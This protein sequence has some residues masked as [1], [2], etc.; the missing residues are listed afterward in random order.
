MMARHYDP[1][2]AGMP[3]EEAWKVHMDLGNSHLRRYF[4]E[5]I[6]HDAINAV[7]ETHQA[8]QLEPLSVREAKLVRDNIDKEFAR[9]RGSLRLGYN[10][11]SGRDECGNIDP[12]QLM[13]V[14]DKVL[15]DTVEGYTSQ[16]DDLSPRHIKRH[17]VDGVSMPDMDAIN[18]HPLYRRYRD[19]FSVMTGL[20]AAYTD[21]EQAIAA[22]EP[23]L[24][25]SPYDPRYRN[26]TN[27]LR[28]GS[29][30][31]S[32][33]L[34]QIDIKNI[35]EGIGRINN[36]GMSRA[37]KL[38]TA[39]PLAEYQQQLSE[40]GPT[41]IPDDYTG[42]SQL[43]N[44][45]SDAE[46]RDVGSWLTSGMT[47]IEGNIDITKCM[48]ASA[49]ERARMI[50][51][52]LDKEAVDYTIKRDSK[53]GQI[54]AELAGTKMRIRL[55]EP[56][57]E[58]QHR[59]IGRV[60][61]D[62]VATRFSSGGQKEPQ[63][64]NEDVLTLIDYARGKQVYKDDGVTRIGANS[65]GS[66]DKNYQIQGSGGSA[67]DLNVEV[68]PGLFIRQQNYTRSELTYFP[69]TP[70]GERAARIAVAEMVSNAQNSIETILN[71]DELIDNY[72]A[73]GYTPSFVGPDV[74]MSVRSDYY[75]ALQGEDITLLYPGY[76]QQEYY[77]LKADIERHPNDYD[78]NEKKELLASMTPDPDLSREE[79]VRDHARAMASSWVGS[80]D[81]DRGGEFDPNIVAQYMDTGRGVWSNIDDLTHA[82]RAGNVGVESVRGDGHTHEAIM[83]KTVRFDP[84]TAVDM[85][86]FASSGL[87][88]EMSESSAA[89]IEQLGDSIVDA[90]EHAGM[91]IVDLKIDDKGVVQWM[92]QRYV[93]DGTRNG[94]GRLTET[95][96]GEIG[97]IFT[98]DDNG[99]VTTRFGN[100][101]NDVNYSFVP[102]YLASVVPPE[103]GQSSTLEQR[104][105]LRGFEQVIDEAVRRQVVRDVLTPR[106][107]VGTPTSI[108]GVY[109][110]LQDNRHP[111][112]YYRP[113]LDQSMTE[114]QLRAIVQTE[115]LTVRY[116]K[117]FINESSTTSIQSKMK[118]RL[119]D[120][121]ND[122][123]SDA[124]RLSGYRDM[125]QL[126]M[127][128]SLG[129]FDPVMTGMATNQGRRRY[130][131]PTAE[132]G[133]D[134]RITPGD[135]DAKIP[136]RDLDIASEMMHDSHDRQNMSLGNAI[137]AVGFTGQR[138]TA[139]YGVPE[140]DDDALIISQKFADDIQVRGVD[141]E[142][143]SL[144]PGDKLSDMHG[145]KGV[146]SMVVNTMDDP[147]AGKE[148]IYHLMA[149]NPELDVIMSPFSLMSRHNGGTSRE[150]MSDPHDLT[151]ENNVGELV[152]KPGGMGPLNFV[153]T[154][155]T[156]D[157]KTTAYDAEAVRA[158]KGRR[159]SDQ[160][161]AA[162]MANKCSTTLNHFFAHNDQGVSNFQERLR[163]LGYDM[164]P[165]GEVT[166]HVS[167]D[168]E[169]RH[170]F[171]EIPLMYKGES[172]SLDMKAMKAAFA[173]QI[174]QQGGVMKVP[175]DIRLR[176]GDV[177][178]EVPVLSAHLR[179][180]QTMDDGQISRHNYTR[181]Y[182]SLFEQSVYVRHGEAMHE[183][184]KE[185][186]N[187]VLKNFEAAHGK[188]QSAYDDIAQY[189]VSKYF[190]SKHNTAKRDLMSVRVPH[191]ATAV[192]YPDTTLKPNEIAIS[193]SLAKVL[194]VDPTK[195]ETCKVLMTRDPVWRSE[196]MK[197][198]DVVIKPDSDGPAIAVHPK[199]VQPMDGDFDGDTVGLIGGLPPEVCKELDNKLSVRGS[200]LDFGTGVRRDDGK[201]YDY[202]LVFSSELSTQVAIYNDE[203]N[204]VDVANVNAHTGS[205]GQRLDYLTRR[206][207]E[208]YREAYE[209]C[210][211]DFRD[212]AVY[213]N[214]NTQLL[215]D[216]DG[217]YREINNERD[218]LS[219][220]MNNVQ[221]HAES[222][223][224]CHVTG[225]KSAGKNDERFNDYLYYAGI[226]TSTNTEGKTVYQWDKP[227]TLADLDERYTDAQKATGVKVDGLP[228]GGARWQKLVQTLRGVGL[229]NEAGQLGYPSAQAMAQA[230]HGA[231]DAVYRLDVLRNYAG[232]LWKGYKMTPSMEN[233]RLAW[234]T[235][236]EGGKPVQATREEW[237]NQFEQLYCSKEGMGL[238]VGEDHIDTIADTFSIDGGD[239]KR[240]MLN[241]D[242][243]GWEDLPDTFEVTLLDKLA[244]SPREATLKD[245]VSVGAQVFN[246]PLEQIQTEKIAFNKQVH[247]FNTVDGFDP[248]RGNEATIDLSHGTVSY[249][250]IGSEDIRTDYERKEKKSDR[251]VRPSQ[252]FVQA[253]AD[254]AI[255]RDHASH[256]VPVSEVVT[257]AK[258]VIPMIPRIPTM[259][260]AVDQSV[261]H[262]P[263][264]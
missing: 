118:D 232:N 15:G 218:R 28:G 17:M 245:L 172:T 223:Y 105:R 264:L 35:P 51:D 19:E 133:M 44:Y 73:E 32:I 163:V 248:T 82:M 38:T 249:Q 49:I 134:G 175:F 220:N 52:H 100:V 165:Y 262:G 47:D 68:R 221:D 98:R 3:E 126:S 180:D 130:L 222:L 192:W 153:V 46:Y 27:V 22:F 39:H 96:T 199:I 263:E 12:Q 150:M 157:K 90:A 42:L 86:T 208:V 174:S 193:E 101:G 109:T 9:N 241:M 36:L 214:E 176:N 59:Y 40:I 243:T 2:T 155:M 194:K 43:R 108:N 209:R 33:N 13:W 66:R 259:D 132:V 261:D 70:E 14:I 201:G 116:A 139:L 224:Q 121:R 135:V 216:I 179:A 62:G 206:A 213:I 246:G 67:L 168:N 170:V 210:G 211:D 178:R 113:V 111:V 238:S 181:Q 72:Q 258:P 25:I 88:G 161:V 75:A 144:M 114:E 242:S 4:Y 191:S 26:R 99:V 217:L 205:Y 57:R 5:F 212:D 83:Q 21:R 142:L 233:G 55:T 10:S 228:F 119:Y 207:N 23:R 219:I 256:D 78:V 58:D 188:A 18:A 182:M 48:S 87:G 129:Y 189:T 141:G 260:G 197:F 143:R 149:D 117:D 167:E 204:E 202:D 37:P 54:C 173:E 8:G 112:D 138:M 184:G 234:S 127:S 6:I 145:N 177:T 31:M 240:Y 93:S 237:I 151:V 253:E 164:T 92:G 203:V 230:K 11:V 61:D 63:F 124:Y 156:A 183:Q 84:A 53:R 77:T 7:G 136:L 187:T 115:A 195:P 110:A 80:F 254:S 103:P 79:Q 95:V 89:F 146:I 244:Y 16:F 171:D 200:L 190:E 34:S 60:Y 235:E 231:A 65:L 252:D 247:A 225:A 169:A 106:T 71:V 140:T 123:F 20:Q 158:G 56:N 160:M 226:S 166:E 107:E 64:S 24:P 30:L 122:N 215:D 236:Y 85:Q 81:P 185:L 147:P 154:P 120:P 45:M 125:R 102:V 198:Q 29:R 131:N 69:P 255:Q 239:G 50:L 94:G 159:V 227:K 250:S 128:T 74:L 76:D 91:E 104:T 229:V 257:Q 251:R 186:K 97:Q 1:S 41:A 137:R 196:G 152:T 148:E 162:L